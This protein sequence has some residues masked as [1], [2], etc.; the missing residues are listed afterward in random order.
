MVL[1][2]VE[3]VEQFV[4]PSHLF[5]RRDLGRGAGG[6][7]LEPERDVEQL[8]DVGSLERDDLHPATGDG[9]DQADTF[10]FHQRGPDRT[11]ADGEPGGERRLGKRFARSELAADDEVTDLGAHHFPQFAVGVAEARRVFEP[12]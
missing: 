9:G 3:V 7:P 8:V 1:R 12:V 2:R 10:E 5:G 6:H 11:A 4:Q